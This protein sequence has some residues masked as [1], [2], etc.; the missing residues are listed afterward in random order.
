[1]FFRSADG[2]E[3][4]LELIIEDKLLPEKKV[5]S[6]LDEANELTAIMADSYISA[7]RSGRDGSAKSAIKNQK[8]A[9]RL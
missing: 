1:L 3:R 7:S 4:W 2:T 8:S 5:R 6:L 9:I